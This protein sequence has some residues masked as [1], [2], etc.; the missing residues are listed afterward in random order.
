[1]GFKRSTDDFGINYCSEPSGDDDE[2][3]TIRA[4]D[5]LFGRPI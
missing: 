2:S 4:T 5:S 3:R 1:V